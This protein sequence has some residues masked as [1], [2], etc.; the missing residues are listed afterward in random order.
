MAARGYVTLTTTPQQ[1]HDGGTFAYIRCASAVLH[2]DTS[3]ATGTAVGSEAL[4]EGTVGTTLAVGRAD[5]EW[6][7]RCPGTVRD[8]AVWAL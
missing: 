6:V 4:I 2:A 5:P 7:C 8:A 1:I 3:G